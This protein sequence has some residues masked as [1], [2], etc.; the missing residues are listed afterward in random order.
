MRLKME[1]YIPRSFN[2][3]KQSFFLF[4]PRGTGKSTLLKKIFNQAVWVDLLKPDLFRRYSA[5]PEY[6]IEL[7]K[8]NPDNKY[9]V[10][11]EIQKVPELLSAVH[12]LIEEEKSKIF[13]LTG[14]SARKLKRTGIDLLSGRVIVRSLHPFLA[15]E[16]KN[17]FNL[18][19]A[20]NIGLLPIVITAKDPKEVLDAYISLYIKEEVQLESLT[21][22]IGNFSR[23]LESISFSHASVLNISNVSREC[24]V[25]RKV[26]ENYVKILEDILL[27]YRIPIFAKKAKRS[28]I[29]HQKFYFFDAG[30]Y[31]TLRPKGPLDKPEDI[32]GTALEGIVMQHLKA[33]NAYRGNKYQIYY[34]RTRKGVEVD[35]ILYGSEGIYSMEVKNTSKIRPEDIRSLQSFKE[36]YPQSKSILLYR[37]KEK[38][39]IK[40]IICLPCDYFLKKLD[41]GKDLKEI[42]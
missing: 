16:L 11:D 21:R 31:N 25:E 34:W 13:I 35:I 9:I 23:F 42:I 37:G 8:G 28:L 20:L 24:E 19:S 26:V 39:L 6:L 41:P 5:K 15:C 27:A 18:E 3:P 36:D 38:L 14:S 4:G 2:V 7:V 22:N 30:V 33:W 10:I 1:L 40:N 17:K 12:H 32:V 29:S